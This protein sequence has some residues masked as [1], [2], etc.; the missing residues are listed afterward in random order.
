MGGGGGIQK[1]STSEEIG[2]ASRIFFPRA[3]STID[4]QAISYFIVNRCFKGK[5]IFFIDDLLFAVITFTACTIVYW[6]M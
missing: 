6:F 5:I 4:E 2:L 1:D 3:P